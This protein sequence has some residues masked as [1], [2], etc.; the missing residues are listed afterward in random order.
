MREF[1]PSAQ[2]IRET[3]A[4]KVVAAAVH[5]VVKMNEDAQQTLLMIHLKHGFVNKVS[6]CCTQCKQFE[7]IHKYNEVLVQ[8]T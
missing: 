1:S 4:G 2:T 3:M 6:R 5:D 7:R 8:T